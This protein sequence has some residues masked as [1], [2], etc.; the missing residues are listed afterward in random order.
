[1]VRIIAGTLLDVGRGKL[2]ADDVIAIMEAKDRR[3]AS[4]TAPA[5]GLILKQIYYNED[6][7]SEL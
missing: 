6:F 1:M 3:K 4:A 2:R 5:C 7:L